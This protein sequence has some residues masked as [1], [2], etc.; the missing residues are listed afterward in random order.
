M[1]SRRV[2][3]FGIAFVRTVILM[4]KW[5]MTQM[6]LRQDILREILDRQSHEANLIDNVNVQ[7]V[8]TETHNLCQL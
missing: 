5:R 4:C 2:V 7:D 6:I 1:L 3:R 8:V